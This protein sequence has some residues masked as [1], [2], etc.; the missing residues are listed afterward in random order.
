MTCLGPRLT[1]NIADT[2]RCL[3]RA[4]PPL[5][6]D[7]YSMTF[8]YLSRRSYLVFAEGVALQAKFLDRWS[9]MLDARQIAALR[10]P[11]RLFGL[12]TAG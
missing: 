8:S 3:H 9:S 7:R 10:P 11:N 1:A 12:H 4:S 6:N 5:A 2:A